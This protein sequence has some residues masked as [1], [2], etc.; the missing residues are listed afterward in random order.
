[1]T[2]GFMVPR[3]ESGRVVCSNGFTSQEA[4]ML[5]YIPL[6]LHRRARKAI[7]VYLQTAVIPA[8]DNG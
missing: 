7:L 8:N 1:M 5:S 2:E 6:C 3:R 4:E